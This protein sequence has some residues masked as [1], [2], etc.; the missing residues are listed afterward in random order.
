M[1]T[2]LLNIEKYGRRAVVGVHG[3][4]LADP[5]NHFYANRTVF[6]FKSAL[7]SDQSV[8]LLG[9]GTVAFHRDTLA[10]TYSDFGEPG[11]AD[12]WFAIAAKR[13]GVPLR[14][15]AHGQGWV[16]SLGDAGQ[17][18]LYVEFAKAVH[19]GCPG[20]VASRPGHHTDILACGP[21]GAEPQSQRPVRRLQ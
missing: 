8:H 13:Q 21:G 10:L 4:V 20:A 16:R 9:T 11:M 12:L 1:P 17:P 14:C 6:H 2:L 18:S 3:I 7:S 5:M 15:I 19:C